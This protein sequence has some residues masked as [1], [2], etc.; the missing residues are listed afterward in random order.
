MALTVNTNTASLN[1]QKNLNRASDALSTSMTRLSSGLK[2]NSAKDDAAGL[3]IAT[4]MTSQIRGQTMAIKNANDGI[5]MAQTAEG[6]LQESTNILQRMRELG[7]QSRNDSNGTLD[8]TALDTEYKAMSDEL[9]RIANSTNLNGTKLLTGTAGT[10]GVLEIQVG[11]GT[12]VDDTIKLDF[13]TVPMDST[14]GGLAV[15]SQDLT[16]AANAKGAIDA[17]DLALDKVNTLRSN[18]GATQNRLSSTISNLQNINENASAALGRVQDTDFAAETAQMTKQQT[19]QQA[20]TAI[21]AQ[22]NQLPSAVLKLLQ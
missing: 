5:S 19:L 2:I 7:V 4:R 14:A 17:I 15:G 21:L 11:S 1:V 22:A 18:L 8:R 3:Q 6:A 16:S 20:S 9:D 12:T 10:G 13:G